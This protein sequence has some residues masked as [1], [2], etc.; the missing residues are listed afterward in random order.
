MREGKIYEHRER[1][2]GDRVKK[3]WDTHTKKE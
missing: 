3:P 1:E 2:S